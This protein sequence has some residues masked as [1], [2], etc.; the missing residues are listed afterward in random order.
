[1]RIP[2]VL[3]RKSRNELSPVTELLIIRLV[4]T[5][6]DR[7]YESLTTDSRDINLGAILLRKRGVRSTLLPPPSIFGID[8]HMK[9]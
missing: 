3:L 2:V 8:L 7:L 9:I 5:Y 6:E 4:L 1:M